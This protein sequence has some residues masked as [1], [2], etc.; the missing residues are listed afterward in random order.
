MINRINRLR[1][2]W[3]SLIALKSAFF[4][5]LVGIRLMLHFAETALCNPL[6]ITLKLQPN[7]YLRNVPS[8]F[9]PLIPLLLIFIKD[10]VYKRIFSNT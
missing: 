1:I 9:V 2:T 4:L 7:F 8:I 10:E 5:P 6:K 3:W